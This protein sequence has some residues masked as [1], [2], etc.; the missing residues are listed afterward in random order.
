M[1]DSNQFQ[2]ITYGAHSNA[3]EVNQLIGHYFKNLE[4]ANRVTPICIW[5]THGIGKTQL[6]ERFAKD[7]G[8][9]FSY[10]APAQFEEMGDLLGLPTKNEEDQTTQFLPPEWVPKQEGPGILLIDDV[11]RADD[12]I[13]RGIMQLL[14]NHE[15]MSWTLP[16]KWMI[17]LTANP[18]GGDYSVTA[19]DDALLTRMAHI[20]MKFDVKAWANWAEGAGIDSRGIS[21]VLTY[22]EIVNNQRTTPRSLVQFFESIKGI[23]KLQEE[24]QLL[25]ILAEANLESATAIAF[26]NFVNMDLNKLVASEEILNAKK[27]EE[28]KK[29]LEKLVDKKPQR[30]DIL[31]V[32][33][34]R[35]TH[36]ILHYED[37]IEGVQFENLSKFMLLTFIPNDLRLSMAQDLVKSNRADMKRLFAVPQIGKLILTKM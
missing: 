7:N 13:L 3:N 22:P 23:E 35:L 19:M 5:G 4:T 37:K 17:V 8:A 14:Q 28:I 11:N 27:F 32:I 9:D 1:K 18:D 10:I 31:S 25:R 2:Y 24:L 21:F 20:T 6:V 36:Y 29:K 12:R 30:L 16:E 34:T 26:T 15:L 33:M